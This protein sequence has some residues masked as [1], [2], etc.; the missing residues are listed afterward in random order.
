MLAFDEIGIRERLRPLIDAPEFRRGLDA[1]TNDPVLLAVFL[2]GVSQGEALGEAGVA[3]IRQD[4]IARL[5]HDLR[6]QE[7]EEH[8]HHAGTRMIVRDL[9][10]ELFAGDRFLHE[11]ALN[12]A[13]YY[14][15]VL[16][17]NRVRL[18]ARGRYTRLN[19]YLTTTFGYEVMVQLLYGAV[20][21]ALRRATRLP[22]R[23]AEEVIVV[24]TM[25]LRQEET[26]LA[27]VEQHNA[28]LAADR[29]A[30]SADAGALLDA[31]GRLTEEDYEWTAE[32]AVREVV[33]TMSCYARPVGGPPAK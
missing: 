29:A 15:G 31:L 3:T 4:E 12:A 20:I 33:P 6:R 26:H 14:F 2:M 19:L 32:L 10:P 9:F 17:A 13:A 24:L 30:L 1:M 18:R 22:S 21:D 5:L 25:I 7:L 27:M 8:G 16:Q 11:D 23:V 28:L